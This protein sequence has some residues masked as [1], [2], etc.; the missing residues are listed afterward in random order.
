MA[1]FAATVAL[2]FLG[3]LVNAQTNNSNSNTA[4]GIA[5]IK[6]N[7]ENAHIIPDL[8]STFNPTAVLDVNFSGVG[9]TPAGQNLTR[10]RKS[11]TELSFLHNNQLSDTSLQRHPPSPNSRSSRAPAST[12]PLQ[13]LIPSSW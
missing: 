6:A 2:S 4:L 8:L 5:G 7:F 10:T 9:E 12:G 13:A 3:P 11:Y 1:L